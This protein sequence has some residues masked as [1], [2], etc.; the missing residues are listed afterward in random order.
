MS[1][2]KHGTL[3]RRERRSEDGES[4]QGQSFSGFQLHISACGSNNPRQATTGGR[5]ERGGQSTL[6]DNPPHQLPRHT[7]PDW[8]VSKQALCLRVLKAKHPRSRCWPIQFLVRVLSLALDSLVC[9][10][11]LF[12]FQKTSL[13]T[14]VFW[15]H[16][17]WA[18]S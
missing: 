17:M 15:L 5:E 11:V 12:C 4:S 14:L 6:S 3:A 16:S 18:G 8:V 7:N 13:L 2:K 9:C 1:V 10:F